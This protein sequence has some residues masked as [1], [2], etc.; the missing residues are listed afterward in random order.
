MKGADDG[1][2]ESEVLVRAITD[3]ILGLKAQDTVDVGSVYWIY[4]DKPYG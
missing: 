4:R 3:G 1:W 2:G